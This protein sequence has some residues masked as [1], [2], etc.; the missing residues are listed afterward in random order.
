MCPVGDRFAV[1]AATLS[2]LAAYAE[3]APTLLLIDDAHLLDASSAEAIRFALR[4][5]LA[6]PL[7]AVLAVREDE[8]SLLDDADLPTLHVVGLDRAAATGLLGGVPAETA[9][10]LYLATAG[11]PLALTELARDTSRLATLA[12][13]API[14][15]PAK[16][17]R[18][19]ARRAALLDASAQR[20][21]A[22]ATVDESADLATIDRAAQLLDLD[23]GGLAAAEKA[24]LVR[25]VS[26]RV[27]FR[28]A[29][30]R[31]AIYG[32]SPPEY[33]REAHRALAR[34]LPDR[35]VGPACLA[36]GS[37]GNRNRRH[38]VR[39]PRAGGFARATAERVCRLER[40]I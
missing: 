37:G 4:R 24:G 38:C 35:D 14:P 34:A 18:A 11:N 17:T 39:S 28:H 40:G 7:G 13:D 23:V 32:A 31:A 36:S 30:A 5:M 19:F 3:E 9:D 27:E 12:I 8:P 29:L 2:L 16:V 22:L 21:L 33:R 10:R 15:V 25:I 6:E 1:G 20:L 26:G